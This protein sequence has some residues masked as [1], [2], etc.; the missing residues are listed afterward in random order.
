MVHLA[1]GMQADNRATV[2]IALGAVNP[3]GNFVAVTSTVKIGVRLPEF[4]CALDDADGRLWCRTLPV[5]P[6]GGRRAAT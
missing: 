1:S 3:L 4:R 2:D 6:R 5:F